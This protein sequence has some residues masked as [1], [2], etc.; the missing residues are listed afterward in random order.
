MKEILESFKDEQGNA[1]LTAE[2][3]KSV[4]AKNGQIVDNEIHKV[5]EK[6]ETSENSYK[7]TISKLEEQVK[8]LPD[9]EE[10]NKIKDELQKM[11]DAEAERVENERIANEQ[12]IKEERTNA[13]F[14]D[15][16]FAS[17]SAKAGVI[18]EFNK[19]DF[20]YDETNKKFIGANEWL[21]DYKKNDAG[22]F[23]SDVANPKFTTNTT[24]PTQSSTN[25]E[26]RKVMGLG[27]KK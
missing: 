6:Y 21:E 25:D 23:L 3:I 22:A 5:K 20:K 9:T 27:E 26:I 4:L 10:L 18:A 11:K 1:K 7:E 13:F 17:N 8:A 19:M 12:S 24:T 2:E 14:N 16:K 15:I